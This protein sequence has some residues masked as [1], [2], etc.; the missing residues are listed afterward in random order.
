MHMLKTKLEPFTASTE[1]LYSGMINSPTNTVPEQFSGESLGTD[2]QLYHK[3]VKKKKTLEVF[4][5]I[6]SE[7]VRFCLSYCSA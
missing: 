3:P 2:H 6:M 4:H 5:F 7:E 1:E